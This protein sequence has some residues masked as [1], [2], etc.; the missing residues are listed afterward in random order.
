M[1]EVYKDIFNGDNLKDLPAKEFEKPW[2]YRTEFNLPGTANGKTIK[3][4][5]EGIIYRA[6]IWLNGKLVADSGTVQGVYRMFEFDV[7]AIVKKSGK[8]ILAVKVFPPRAANLP[9]ALLIGTRLHRIKIRESGE[10]SA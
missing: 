5:F 2:W 7:S 10:M 1:T 9:S 6:E 3:L 8:N 4:K